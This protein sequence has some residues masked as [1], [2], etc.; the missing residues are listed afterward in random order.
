MKAAI[1]WLR[2]YSKRFPARFS[3]SRYG[4]RH[5]RM[6]SFKRLGIDF[7]RL[8]FEFSQLSTPC[9]Q[10]LEAGGGSILSPAESGDRGACFAA[11]FLG[12]DR[13]WTWFFVSPFDGGRYDAVSGVFLPR[14]TGAN[15]AFHRDIFHGIGD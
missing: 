11:A 14:H 5:W 2:N 12:V 8:R 3:R 9:H 6:F 13:V 1:H 4:A 10:S 15:F 7:G